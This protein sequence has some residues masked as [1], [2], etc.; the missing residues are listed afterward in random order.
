GQV[1]TSPEQPV[2][3]RRDEREPHEQGYVDVAQAPRVVQ[4]VYGQG[5]ELAAVGVLV[6]DVDVD[7]AVRRRIGRSRIWLV[8]RSI[9]VGWN[10]TA[11]GRHEVDLGVRE[12]GAVERL[13]G[14]RH[15]V[16]VVEEQIRA[17][18]RVEPGSVAS[19]FAGGALQGHG[20]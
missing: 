4:G 9:A 10:E 20:V 12:A 6:A 7:V 13:L 14:R 1:D 5:S 19:T 18:G 8:D 16:G 2:D 17:G 11:A 3:E 15:D